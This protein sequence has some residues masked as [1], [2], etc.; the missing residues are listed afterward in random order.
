MGQISP[1]GFQSI[2][3]CM[4]WLCIYLNKISLTWLDLTWLFCAAYWSR[5]PRVFRRLS[6]SCPSSY[7]FSQGA[8]W[9]SLSPCTVINPILLTPI[10]FRHFIHTSHD[11][12][13]ICQHLAITETT[14]KQHPLAF[15]WF[16]F[17]WETPGSLGSS[18]HARHRDTGYPVCSTF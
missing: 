6:R 3:C 15:I 14:V 8:I 12:I 10:G 5:Q 1:N 13:F 9:P 11:A 4:I 7:R 18:K 2:Q 16:D 17:Y